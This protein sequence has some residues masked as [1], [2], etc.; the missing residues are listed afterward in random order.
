MYLKQLIQSY[1]VIV[2]TVH[3]DISIYK[4]GT[5]LSTNNL[6]MSDD[7]QTMSE[8]KYLECSRVILD[9]YYSC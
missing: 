4:H 7:I 3:V 2:N 1:I 8:M 5:L 9:R 6:Y